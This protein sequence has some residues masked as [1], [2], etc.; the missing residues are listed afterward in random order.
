MNIE[1]TIMA[2]GGSIRGELLDIIETWD[3]EKY[4]DLMTIVLVVLE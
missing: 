3:G 2:V 1:G 4:G